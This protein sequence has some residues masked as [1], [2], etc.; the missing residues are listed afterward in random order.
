M[1]NFIAD[2]QTMLDGPA[3][4]QP[5]TNRMKANRYQGRV[6]LWSSVFRAPA[7]GTAPAIAD[8][9]I[10]GRMPVKSRLLPW[11]GLLAYNA[12]T[13]S[14]TL[15]LGDQFLAT[16]YLAATAVNAAGQ[17][18]LTGGIIS[19]TATADVTISSAV[20]TNVKSLGAFTPNGILTGTG[21]PTA[22][23]VVSVDYQ[24]K[25]VTM[26]A[27]ATATNAAQTITALGAPYE[28]QDDTSNVANAYASTT[29]DCTLISVVAGAQVAN[30]QMIS[31]LVPF[32]Q[33]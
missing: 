20:L 19:N 3:F 27:V 29:D 7:S 10:W 2:V 30:N 11:L 21:I 13:A 15:N 9:I 5:L 33:D 14:C 23:F 25:T 6:R 8:K 4:G 12:G 1:A 16:R 26:S 28:T 32:V 17:T 24:A 18:A 22:T 31:L